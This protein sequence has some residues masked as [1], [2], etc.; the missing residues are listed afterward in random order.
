[1]EG[2]KAES[3]KENAFDLLLCFDDA[4]SLGYRECVSLT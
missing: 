1:V 3:V 2:V 4:I